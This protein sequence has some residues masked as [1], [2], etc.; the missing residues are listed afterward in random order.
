MVERK[1]KEKCTETKAYTNV[2]VDKEWY[3]MTSLSQEWEHRVCVIKDFQ[4]VQ[5][6]WIRGETIQWALFNRV[7]YKQVPQTG[8]QQYGQLLNLIRQTR[9]TT[10]Y[11]FCE[12][13]DQVENDLRDQTMRY[14]LSL[15][16][17]AAFFLYAARRFHKL[18]SLS[19]AGGSTET[20]PPRGAEFP[21]LHV[22][23]SCSIEQFC[24]CCSSAKVQLY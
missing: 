23:T 8:S 18:S 13:P 7:L 20:F 9:Q 1:K 16:F 12:A 17:T 4:L 3:D 21:S 19:S 24:A 22:S 15:Y 10:F 11:R 14:E 2:Q 6:K 5:R